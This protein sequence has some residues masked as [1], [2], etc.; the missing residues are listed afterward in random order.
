LLVTHSARWSGLASQAQSSYEAIGSVFDFGR[1]GGRVLQ[2]R[3][4]VDSGGRV[5]ALAKSRETCREPSAVRYRVCGVTG[6]LPSADKASAPIASV[7]P[8]P[9][10]RAN[11][12]T[13]GPESVSESCDT[14]RLARSHA[15]PSSGPRTASSVDVDTQ[16]RPFLARR[17]RN[18]VATDACGPWTRRP[19]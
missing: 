3:F 18:S 5:S 13:L 1:V 7:N 15:R 19:R 9:T 11:L 17:A 10:L 16:D 14:P 12:S 4:G 2:E 8:G 6:H